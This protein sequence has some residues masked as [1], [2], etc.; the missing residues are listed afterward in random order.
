[1]DYLRNYQYPEIQNQ[2]LTSS[3]NE[4][5]ATV[6]NIYHMEAPYNQIPIFF[7]DLIH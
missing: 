6:T 5:R 2:D 1:M 7:P 3:D 4:D